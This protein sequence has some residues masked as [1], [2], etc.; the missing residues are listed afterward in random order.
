MHFTKEYV[1]ELEDSSITVSSGTKNC[2]ATR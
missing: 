2:E 1:N